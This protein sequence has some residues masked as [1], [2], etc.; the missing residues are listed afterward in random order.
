MCSC[1]FYCVVE[2][3]IVS[4][5]NCAIMVV[6]VNEYSDSHLDDGRKR[7]LMK[8]RWKNIIYW[9]F[10]FRIPGDKRSYLER[11]HGLLVENRAFTCA[12]VAVW[13]VDTQDQ[14]FCKRKYINYY[15]Y[16]IQIFVFTI[17]NECEFWFQFLWN[18]DDQKQLIRHTWHFITYLELEM[19]RRV[20]YW[21]SAT[22]V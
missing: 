13:K 9:E 8:Y 10:E 21:N 16:R 19:I 1:K 2:N 15:H 18:V 11:L 6:F 7:D 22:Y 12:A 5:K 17:P 14:L 3:F 4:T 20:A